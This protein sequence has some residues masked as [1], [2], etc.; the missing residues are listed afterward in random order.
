MPKRSLQRRSSRGFQRRAFTLVETVLA[1]AVS[2]MIMLACAQLLFDTAHTG[3]IL[4]RGGSLRAH[5]DG[6]E[7]FLTYA[8]SRSNASAL[9]F[10][11]SLS[12]KSGEILAAPLPDELG[13]NRDYRVVFTEKTAHPL[14]AAPLGLSPEKVCY[15]DFEEDAG[16]FIV[17]HFTQSEDRKNDRAIYKTRISPYASEILYIY[18]DGRRWREEPQLTT[19]T[20]AMPEFVKIKF[21]R[22][23]ETLERIIALSPRIDYQISK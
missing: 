8:F 11:E 1:L 13:G 23:G 22:S 21:S 2:A 5:A 9:T 16:L 14:Y 17:W 3:E 19:R 7:K 12:N 18:N 10:D 15:L 20:E 4:A 6:V